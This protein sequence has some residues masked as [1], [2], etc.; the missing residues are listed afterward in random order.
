MTGPPERPGPADG[1]D[2]PTP[3]G[4]GVATARSLADLE[5]LPLTQAPS[6]LAACGYPKRWAQPEWLQATHLRCLTVL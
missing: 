6:A 5:P 2:T 1:M 3:V 4:E